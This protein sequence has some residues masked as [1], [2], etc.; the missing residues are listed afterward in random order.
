MPFMVKRLTLCL[1]FFATLLASNRIEA[2]AQFPIFP[3][4]A[5]NVRFWEKIY[6][7]YSAD[8]G[9][10][11]DK[12]DLNIVYAVIDLVPRS[13][14]GAATINGKLIK[15]IRLRHE[16]ILKKFASGKKPSTKEEKK[17]FSLFKHKKSS[18]SFRRASNNIRLQTGLKKAFREGVI[19][20]GAYMPLIKRI[21]RARGLPVE[22][23]YLPH[24]ESSFNLN[25]YSKA[26]AVGLWQFTK[27][28]GRDYLTVNRLIDERFDV[29]L[30]SR[31]AARFLKENHR[32]LGSWPLAL[33]AYNYG[34]AGMVRAQKKWG[35]Y[36][37]IIVNHKT[38]I[39]K[40]ASKNFYSEFIAAVRVARR[41]ENDRSLVKN[42]PWINVTF[43]LRGYAAAKDLRKYFNV[44][45][46]DF[47]RLNPA[48]RQPVLEGRKYIP[49][50]TLIRLPATKRIR[51]RIKE[52]PSR[53]FY[54]NQIRDKEYKVKKGDT[55]ISI[56]AKFKISLKTLLQVNRLGHKARIR[57]GQKLR[58]PS[59]SALE[60]PGGDNTIITLEA[61][62]KERIQLSVQGK[63]TITVKNE[64]IPIL[65]T[66]SKRTAN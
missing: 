4:I 32:Q 12:N 14:P 25:A 33:T 3:L 63:S 43:R 11:H 2:G 42:R 20:S 61:T 6:G 38:G 31:A 50:G 40:F 55:A 7:T 53:L 13:V 16:N 60:T 19:R 65:D 1:L 10:L 48:L 58:I 5:P 30:S 56:A 17:I 23:A 9:V 45:R 24:V 22:L 41:L 8:Q 44:T 28:T 35:S 15:L 37:A 54:T 46:D 62:A 47:Q 27:H 26:A 34:R 29:Y 39:F 57:L 36:P 21:M 64:K 66:T 59:R 49:Q 52:M 18:S 51:R